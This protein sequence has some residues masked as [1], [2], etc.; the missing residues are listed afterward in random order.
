MPSRSMVRAE[1][2]KMGLLVAVTAVCGLLAGPRAGA[3]PAPGRHDA[4]VLMVSDIHF[5]PFWDPGKVADLATNNDWGKILAAPDSNGRAS[6]FATLERTCNVK[7]NDTSYP[8]FESSLAAMRKE[9]A[10]ALFI[11]LSGDLMAHEFDCKFH[12]MFPHASADDDQSFAAKTVDYVVERLHAAF[13]HALLYAALGNNDSGCGDYKLDTQDGF[14]A[15]VAPAIAAGFGE[16]ETSEAVRTLIAGGY[17]SAALPAPFGNTEMLVLD[18]L[19]MSKKYTTCAGK[20][21]DAGAAGQLKWLQRQLDAAR[22][23]HARV[24][25]MAHIPPGVD[26][27]GTISKMR[28]V[29]AGQKPEMFLSGDAL[30]A[31]LSGYGDVIQL[32][33]FAH[34]HMDELRLLPGA[35]EG[36]PGV[37]IKMVPSISPVDGN[38]PAF[39]VAQVDAQT[40]ALADYRVY[41]ASNKTGVDTVWSEEYDFDKAYGESEFTAGTVEKLIARFAADPGAKT[42]AG[43]SYLEHYFVGDASGEIKPFWPEYV[44]ALGNYTAAGFTACQCAQE[45]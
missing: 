20:S 22:Q 19:Y 41:A 15:L 2:R 40:A 27:Y 10:G 45:K 3:E 30:P 23:A 11:T 21:D 28:D 25:V 31:L 24:W 13:P 16:D 34:T 5:D 18:D 39:T 36:E 6:Q 43:E 4:R 1:C 37:A 29:C 38:D 42:S 7:G 44:C 14:L 8:L 17:Y 32:A 33:I 26:P 35:K 12:T 9:A